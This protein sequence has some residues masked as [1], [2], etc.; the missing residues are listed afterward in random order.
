MVFLISNI[1]L[2]NTD[3]ID[4]IYLK[5]EIYVDFSYLTYCMS[6]SI[7]NFIPYGSIQLAVNLSILHTVEGQ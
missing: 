1:F 2:I 3:L 5:A 7:R 6:S 4:I